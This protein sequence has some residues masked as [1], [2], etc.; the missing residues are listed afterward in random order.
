MD[1]LRNIKTAL[2]EL[3]AELVLRNA[4]VI[5]VLTGEIVRADVAVTDGTIVGVGRYEAGRETVDLN[6]RYLAP[7]F[8]NAHCHVESSM[9]TPWQY[10]RE[11]LRHGVTT[12]ITDPHEIANVA[13]M[14]GVRYMLD[15][16]EDVPVNY[17]VQ[18]PSCVPAT[19]FEHAG[20]VLTAE[21]LLE[22]KRHPRVLGLGEMMNYPGVI[23]CDSNVLAK[24]DAFSDRI[25]DGHAPGVTGNGLQAYAAAGIQT[26][27]ESVTWEEAREKLR[28]GMAVLIR[29]GS[30]SRN[31]TELVRGLLRD[32]VDTSNMAFCTDDKHLADIRREGTIRHN[33]CMAVALGM[34]PVTAIQLGTRNAARIYGVKGLGA[35]APGCRADMVVL[36]DLRDFT[37]HEVYKDGVCVVRA[38][39]VLTKE[40]PVPAGDRICHS[41][42]LAPL[43]QRDLSLPDRGI[44][45]VIALQPGQITTGHESVETG[46]VEREM[47]AGALRKIAVLERHHATGHVGVGLISGYGLTHGAVATTVAHDSHNLIVVGDNDDDMRA[48]IRKIETMEGG[49]CLTMDGE[50]VGAL[51]LPVAGLMSDRPADE[52]IPLLE[53]LLERARAMGVAPG[54]DPFTTLSFVAL[55]VIP[56]L[57]LTDAG[58]FDVDRFS[59]V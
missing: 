48:A 32:G 33:M 59:F 46:A 17:Y 41:V 26:D 25:I 5:N 49:Y 54:I 28:A 45:P 1:L 30:A 57:R 11:E 13:G 43:G 4:R 14:E 9:V 7:G 53:K 19:G 16:S 34:A 2:G 36:E 8:I 51:P 52:F 6:G 47:A 56:A 3:R 35:V 31:L 55:P 38:G 37:V 10:C 20:A 12:L 15:A 23:G 24:L 50:V 22:L 21:K 40:T 58:M 39:E 18:L 44:Q 27:H 29:E 42:H